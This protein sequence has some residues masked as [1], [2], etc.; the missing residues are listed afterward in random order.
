MLQYITHKPFDGYGLDGYMKIPV[1]AKLFQNGKYLFYKERKLCLAESK[2]CWEHFHLNTP[3]GKRRYELTYELQEHIDEIDFPIELAA[4]KNP[5]A[6]AS[7]KQLQEL[8]NTYILGG[9]NK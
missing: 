4:E 3:E 5:L 7:E 2:L 8:Y 6:A 1:G 9:K